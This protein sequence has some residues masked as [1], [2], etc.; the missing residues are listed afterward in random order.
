MLAVNLLVVDGGEYS[1]LVL[2]SAHTC[3]RV[4]PYPCVSRSGVLGGGSIRVV[5]RTGLYTRRLTLG[6]LFFLLQRSI[7]R[8]SC[9]SWGALFLIVAVG[10]CSVGLGFLGLPLGF[11]PVLVVL[12]LLGLLLHPPLLLFPPL[13][14][15]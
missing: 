9:I 4:S 13:C 1:M 6:I 5:L 11:L 8:L 12:L 2:L 15:S 14:F 7:R 10:C 3:L